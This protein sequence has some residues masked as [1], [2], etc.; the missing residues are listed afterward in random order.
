MKLQKIIL[1]IGIVMIV[2]IG[3]IMTVLSVE[4]SP[5]INLSPLNHPIYISDSCI[6][7][8]QPVFGL[9]NYDYNMS[10][11]FDVIIINSSDMTVRKESFLLYPGQY[12]ESGFKISDKDGI[13]YDLTFTVDRNSTY[14]RSVNASI[15]SVH[16][17]NYNPGNEGI[18]PGSLFHNG[19]ACP[20][21]PL[22]DSSDRRPQY[23]EGL[24]YYSFGVPALY[25]HDVGL[26]TSEELYSLLQRIVNASE[27]ELTPYLYPGGPVIGY[28]YDMDG[29]VIIQINEKCDVNRSQMTDMYEIIKGHGIENGVQSVPCKFLSTGIIRMDSA[30][31]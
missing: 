22:M 19:F 23:P 25:P 5:M 12:L 28:G 29:T 24:V 2:W 3:G 13:R 1:I 6:S 14:L 18:V 4:K 31:N 17:F 26:N 9:L 11:R 21:S 15:F 20:K 30:G 8:L 10:H 27:E 7:P 16:S